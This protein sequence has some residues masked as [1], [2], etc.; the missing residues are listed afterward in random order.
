MKETTAALSSAERIAAKLGGLY[1]SY[2]YKRYAMSRFEEYSLYIDNRDFLV[3]RNIITFSGADGK[4][5]ALRPDVTLSIVKNTNAD[6]EHTEKL[7]YNESVYRLSSDNLGYSEIHQTGVE[8][9]GNV[10]DCTMAETVELMLESLA[11]L[12]ER[13][14]LDLS[15]GGFIGG[16]VETLGLDAQ[17]LP[18]L[19]ELLR[20]KNLH[21]FRKFAQVNGVDE[22]RAAKFEAMLQL[23]GSLSQALDTADRIADN[24][25]AR[26]AIEQLRALNGALFGHRAYDKLELDFSIVNHLDYYDGI[27]CNG[28]VQDVPK[29]V[30]VGGRYDKLLTKL[31]KRA[32]AIGFALNAD[33]LAQQ[34]ARKVDFV[35]L[36]EQGSDVRQV[37]A[38]ARKLRETGVSVRIAREMPN[39]RTSAVL[40]YCDGGVQE[41]RI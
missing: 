26:Q 10:D 34:P 22:S 29:A 2:G 33:A 35:L 9:I 23:R 37:L 6:V 41:V 7:Y 3:D 1:R 25:R 19:Y 13:F 20:A 5:L 39:V 16:M 30:L 15:H 14:V 8:T 24:P 12:S 18:K 38:Q 36:Y 40:R 17:E 4:L 21:E 27:L 32:Q 31:G 11:M 28:F